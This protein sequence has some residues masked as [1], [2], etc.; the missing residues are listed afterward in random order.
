M[1][2]QT[3][4]KGDFVE[5]ANSGT[6]PAGNAGSPTPTPAPS[7]AMADLFKGAAS[8]EDVLKIALGD[9]G[10]AMLESHTGPLK[11]ALDGER[12]SVKTLKTQV[13]ELS[14]GLEEIRTKQE[15][16]ADEKLSELE[17]LRKDAERSKQTIV[18]LQGGAAQAKAEARGQA[19]RT[20]VVSVAAELGFASPDDAVAIIAADLA[21][22]SAL[23]SV[24]EENQVSGVRDALTKIL[25][26]KPYLKRDVGPVKPKPAPAL[27]AT[28]PSPEATPAQETYEQRR[29]RIYG[30]ARDVLSN[31]N[32]LNHGGGVRQPVTESGSTQ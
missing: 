6:E 24:S 21:A 25:E 3:N 8:V 17:K 13:G 22:N 19:I 12:A 14:T 18:D 31:E 20:R 27:G 7:G 30:N 10:A 26:L 1:S 29:K 5:M 32:I 16:K 23:L 11:R 2:C 9:A 15:A 4:H 28:D